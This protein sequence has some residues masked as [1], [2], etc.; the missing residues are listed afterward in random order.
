MTWASEKKQQPA[1]T[2]PINSHVQRDRLHQAQFAIELRR[3][4]VAAV[5]AKIPEIGLP[6]A[7]TNGRFA[8]S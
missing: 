5:H 6:P 8:V 7:M 1:V 2:P 3:S 4:G